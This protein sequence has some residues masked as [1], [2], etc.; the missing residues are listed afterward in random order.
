VAP[1]NL[2]YFSYYKYFLFATLCLS[3]DRKLALHDVVK[4]SFEWCSLKKISY[5]VGK[6]RT[7]SSDSALFTKDR[8][9]V[10]RKN[11]HFVLGFF[12]NSFLL[13]VHNHSVKKS[14]GEGTTLLTEPCSCFSSVC[15]FLQTLLILG[16]R[17]DQP[18]DLFIF[19]VLRRA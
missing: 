13:K 19:I 1:E 4:L 14:F 9:K 3:R 16:R 2:F 6:T 7:L 15:R 8:L 17:H 18:K 11:C 5:A 12:K 10:D